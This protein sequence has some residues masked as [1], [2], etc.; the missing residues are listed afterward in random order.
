ML[1][2]VCPAPANRLFAGAVLAEEGRDARVKR[3]RLADPVLVLEPGISY[4]S[5]THRR[6]RPRR[7]SGIE[8][9]HAC[10]PFLSKFHEV[11]LDVTVPRRAD[12]LGVGVVGLRASEVRQSPASLRS[13]RRSLF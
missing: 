6:N 7:L 5:G 3:R 11:K 9:S 1:V 12:D 10:I 13:L 2:S 8:V 4:R